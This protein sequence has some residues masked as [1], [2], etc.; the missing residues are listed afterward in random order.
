MRGF[1][2]GQ[3]KEGRQVEHV[4][5]KQQVRCLFAGQETP[6]QGYCA[7]MHPPLPVMAAQGQDIDLMSAV[8]DQ[9]VNPG[10]M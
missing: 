8:S 4:A 9:L 5:G 2:P 7:T 3:G 10:S 6:G 1:C